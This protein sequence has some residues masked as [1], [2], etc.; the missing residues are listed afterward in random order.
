M[1]LLSKLKKLTN[2]KS[3]PPEIDISAIQDSIGNEFFLLLNKVFSER[4]KNPD[5]THY[6]SEQIGAL[7]DYYVKKN[8]II[9]ASSSLVP[10]PLGILSAVPELVMTM[11][12]HMKMIYDYGCV[13]D[14][15][16]FLNKDV[17]LEIPIH[18]F[19]GSTNL[20]AIQVS[21]TDLQDSP[22]NIL[23][24]KAYE[25]GTVMINK[26]MKKSV[27]KMV[28]IAG[29][30]M[31]SIWAK[32][33]TRNIAN[34]ALNFFDDCKILTPPKPKSPDQDIDIEFNKIKMLIN[35]I[36]SDHEIDESELKFILP[37]IENS[38]ISE[39]HKEALLLEANK[40]E[41]NLEVDI[42]HFTDD[43]NEAESLITDL[44]ILAKRDGSIK[45]SEKHYLFQVADEVNFDQM[46]LDDLLQEEV[47]A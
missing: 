34:S 19:G 10:G 32:S 14:K 27:I 20:A 43:P 38:S 28:P 33:S 24:E 15:E 9:A 3:S 5:N 16:G 29:T 40:T 37:V 13:F 46:M 11:G 6:T 47:Q 39:A 25:M 45:E 21:Q 7:Q 30:V 31:M 17:L 23:I 8:L 41:S 26:T 42:S 4:Q 18:A 12:N 22:E 36:E 1:K 35:L 2:L 44:V